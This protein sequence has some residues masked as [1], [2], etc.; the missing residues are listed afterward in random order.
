MRKSMQQLKRNSA[1]F[2]GTALITLIFASAGGV[3]TASA[4][5]DGC[6]FEGQW[7]CNWY[8]ENQAAG[9][10]HWFVAANTLRYW[11]AGAITG[12]NGYYVEQKCT[13]ITT[14]AGPAYQVACGWGYQSG[15]VYS[16]WRPGYLW[17][18]HGASGSRWITGHGWH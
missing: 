15:P 14:N 7:H 5:N 4:H 10:M 17:T 18:R 12:V 8:D 1:V 2:L 11:T 16:A 13:H 9:A 3:S 6:G